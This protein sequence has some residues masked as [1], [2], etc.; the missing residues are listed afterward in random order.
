MKYNI[1]ECFKMVNQKSLWI[2]FL[3]CIPF[4]FMN[5]QTKQSIPVPIFLNILGIFCSFFMAMLIINYIK[6]YISNDCNQ[7][8]VFAEWFIFNFKGA[9]SNFLIMVLTYIVT[10][11]EVFILLY[12]VIEC[13]YGGG[14]CDN[15]NVA[16]IQILWLILVFVFA[17]I[18]LF[19]LICW[20]MQP[21]LFYKTNKILSCFRFPTIFK[22]IMKNKIAILKYL[23]FSIIMGFSL[24]FVNNY[25]F[26]RISFIYI[27]IQIFI[28]YLIIIMNLNLLA[29]LS[30][31]ISQ[32]M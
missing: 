29:Q 26:D 9:V 21:L 30:K 3:L 25:T 24:F 15:S 18:V 23:F 1:K 22:I 2:I 12:I 27:F 4:G 31:H 16:K 32:R 7:E 28:E 11:I 13:S 14:W 10:I 20:A 8:N 17:F 5:W 6:N 19:L